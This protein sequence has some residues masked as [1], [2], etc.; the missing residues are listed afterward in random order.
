MRIAVLFLL[1]ALGQDQVLFEDKFAGKPADGWTWLREDAGGWKVEGGAL[2]IKAQPG[3]LWYKTKTAKNVAVRKLGAAGTAE[4]PVAI[5]VTVESAP[6]ANSEQCGLYLHFDDGN[7]VKIIR[8]H[9]KGKNNILMVREVKNIPEPQKPVEE[10]AGTVRLRLVWS[11]AKVHGFYKT[12]G[13]WVPVGEMES[14]S[15]DGAANAALASHGGA[16]DSDHWAKFT[17][18]RVVK[19]GK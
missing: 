18:F 5:E 10:A 1:A 13:D 4:A 3:K 17:D 2:K 15:P 8:E 14:P 12:T 9:L 16:P 7:F 19:P 11:G 6:D